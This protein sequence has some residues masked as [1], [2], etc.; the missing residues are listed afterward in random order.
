MLDKGYRIVYT[1]FAKLFHYESYSKK[2][3]ADLPE[4]KYMKQ[5]WA[6]YINDDPYYNPNLTRC[7]EDYSLRYDQVFL[8]KVNE[9]SQLSPSLFGVRTAAAKKLGRLGQI[10]FYAAAARSAA[11]ARGLTQTT[12][13]WDVAGP[14]KVQIRVG[15]PMGTIFVEGRSSGSATTGPWVSPG[16]V[17]YLLDAT[18]GGSGSPDKVLSVLQV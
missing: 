11:D 10:K 1:P 13:F 9:P 5:R 17:F 15:S 16:I 14:E 4:L 2:A 3:V 18:D 7:A 12:V 8:R 6:S